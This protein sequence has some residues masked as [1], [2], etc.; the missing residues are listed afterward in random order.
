MVALVGA[1]TL[2]AARWVKAGEGEG[3]DLVQ[4]ERAPFTA[5]LQLPAENE[6]LDKCT[7][8]GCNRSI[9]W[10]ATGPGVVT[11]IACCARSHTPRGFSTP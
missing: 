9:G 3:G 2:E 10:V 4:G 6:A 5:M 1:P 8:A 7:C 11:P